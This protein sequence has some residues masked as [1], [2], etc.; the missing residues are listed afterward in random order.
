MESSDSDGGLC[1]R[2]KGRRAASTC[3]FR[4]T[5][6]HHCGKKGHI[7]RACRKKIGQAHYISGE[8]PDEV[9]AMFQVMIS[10]VDHKPPA[11]TLMV[12]ET[13]LHM[14]VD[15][16]A[17]VTVIRESTY[18]YLRRNRQ[19]PPLKHSKAMLRTYTGESVPVRGSVTLNV[20]YEDRQDR[21]R[22]FVVK[23]R[24]PALLGRDWQMRLGLYQ[25][26]F[27]GMKT[28]VPEDWKYGLKGGGM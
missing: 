10:T 7:A 3:R 18:R 4:R 12:Q 19:A 5:E 17:A 28:T 21:L 20:R 25:D 2:C 16:G 6:C 14:Q 24:G 9:Y 27:P 23:G 8:A 13:Q 26:K 1:F 15:T 22:L 11:A